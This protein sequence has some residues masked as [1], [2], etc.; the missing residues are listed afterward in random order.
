MGEA[1]K[2]SSYK[3]AVYHIRDENGHLIPKGGASILVI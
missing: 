3:V 2:R 1:W